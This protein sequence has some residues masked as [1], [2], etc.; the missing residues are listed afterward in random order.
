MIK[1]IYY[2]RDQ[3]LAVIITVIWI[4]FTIHNQNNSDILIQQTKKLEREILVLEEKDRQSKIII[5]SLS[6][7]D[8]IIVTKIKTI[9]Q[10]EYVQIKIIDSIPISE[11]QEYFSKRYPK[12]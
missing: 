1:F 8:T 4:F 2:L 10:K 7:V 12:R 9:K 5:D 11:L 3:Y 6:R